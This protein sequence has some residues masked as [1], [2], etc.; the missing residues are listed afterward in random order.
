MTWCQIMDLKAKKKEVYGYGTL[1]DQGA[2]LRIF[3]FNS[4]VSQFIL[5][6]ILG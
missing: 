5:L 2:L 3:F 4:K 6:L 1:S